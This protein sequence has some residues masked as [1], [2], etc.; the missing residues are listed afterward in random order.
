MNENAI[1]K[2]D[3]IKVGVIKKYGLDDR[4]R[5]KNNIIFRNEEIVL[6]QNIA[7]GDLKIKRNL[8]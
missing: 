7:T 1:R 4:I 3:E 5:T 6:I 2:I 8:R